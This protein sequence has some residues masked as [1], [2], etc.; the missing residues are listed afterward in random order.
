MLQGLDGIRGESCLQTIRGFSAI[1]IRVAGST[2]ER[3]AAEQIAS[4]FSDLG[5]VDVRLQ[6]FPC[7]TFVHSRCRV[8]VSSA[9]K[10]KTIK[11][12]PAALSP[13]TA[14]RGVE[15][16]LTVLED[17]P[18]SGRQ[19]S[20]N[21]GG[22]VV[23]MYAS[24]LF[25]WS[26]LRRI[27]EAKPLAIL[28]VDDRFHGDW[29]VAV[30]FPRFWVDFLTCPIVNISYMDAWNLV[31]AG[32]EAARVSVDST[33]AEA[34]SQNVIGEIRGTDLPVEVIVISAHHD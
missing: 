4:R 8:S 21:I 23:L 26:R 14:A 5:L 19:G 28:L 3:Q 18:R 7:L 20:A 13:S 29:T 31:S 2:G 34:V 30:G 15:G 12:E 32:A 24:L 33:V 16:G 17:A 25:D 9:G 27:M 22:R 10:L 6:E 11:S 1:G